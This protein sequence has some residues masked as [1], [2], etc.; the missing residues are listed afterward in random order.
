[1]TGNLFMYHKLNSA[2]QKSAILVQGVF[3]QCLA[4]LEVIWGGGNPNPPHREMALVRTKLEEACF[5]AK[6]AVAL[7]DRNQEGK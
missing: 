5:Y 4:D 1:M 7:D 2:G 6:K 3:E